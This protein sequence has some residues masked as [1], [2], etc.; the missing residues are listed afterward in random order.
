[1]SES[2]A[3]IARRMNVGCT[4]LPA[5]FLFTEATL[6]PDVE[7]T[8]N[9]LPA[10]CAVIVRDYELDHRHQWAARWLAACR[11]AGR[12]CLIAGHQCNRIFLDYI[13]NNK[14]VNDFRN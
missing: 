6:M 3:A 5:L 7:R 10:D 2:L 9:D 1:M 4:G 11:R 8:V 14:H 13:F 12:P